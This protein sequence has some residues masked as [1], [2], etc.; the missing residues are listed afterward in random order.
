MGL[1]DYTVKEANAL[2][3]G[4]KGRLTIT[5]TDIHYGKYVALTM[6]SDTVFAALTDSLNQLASGFAFSSG[7]TTEVAAGTF[8]RG[9]T[10]G[11]IVQ[12]KQV[13]LTSGSWAGGDATGWLIAEPMNTTGTTA[14]EN[15][16]IV[17]ILP[18]PDGATTIPYTTVTSNV[19]T[20]ATAANGG[21]T[22]GDTQI[23]GT[24][25]AGTTLFGAFTKIQ[26]LSGAIEAYKG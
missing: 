25:L 14:S 18:V 12:V 1:P 26:L 20:L 8:L 2:L 9:A 11:S 21:S 10:S 22:T 16:D 23:G 6:L 4:Q 13:T 15:M 7:G 3:L 19:M 17:T 5:D 24:Y